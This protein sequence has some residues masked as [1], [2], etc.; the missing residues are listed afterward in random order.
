MALCFCVIGMLFGFVLCECGVVL[1]HMIF[2]PD[3]V[4]I[5]CCLSAHVHDVCE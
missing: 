1:V 4:F 3:V 2:E 5:G